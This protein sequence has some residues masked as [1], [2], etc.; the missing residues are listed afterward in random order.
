MKWLENELKFLY[1]NYKT[2]TSKEISLLLNRSKNSI[3]A[4]I[5]RLGL[6]RS[7]IWTKEE[8]EYLEKSYNI[9]DVSIISNKL[10]K[11][12]ESIINKASILS[13]KS[14]KTWEDYEIEILKNNYGIKEIDEY[15]NLLKNRSINSI[16][17]KAKLLSL[18][19]NNKRFRNKYKYDINHKYFNQIN[20]LNSYWAGFIAADGYVKRNSSCLGIKLSSLD[21]EHLNKFKKDIE[22][23]SPIFIKKGLSFDKEVEFCEMNLYSRFIVNDIYKNFNIGSN[24]TLSI[25]FPNFENDTD[26]LSFICGLIDGDGSISITNNRISITILGTF[27]MLENVKSTLNSIIDVSNINIVKKSKIYSFCITSSINDTDSRIIKLYNKVKELNI[28]LLER[29]WIKING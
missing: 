2:K 9:L 29:K 14:K 1:D 6:D 28:P 17:H 10:N 20:K 27:N 24:K 21:I 5:I 25:T 3:D 26:K 23:N 22:T 13:L 8:I 16:R 19:S 11:T 15:I 4:K 12:K 18:T 7:N